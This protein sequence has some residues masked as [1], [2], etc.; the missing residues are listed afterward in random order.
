MQ[1]FSG[2]SLATAAGVAGEVRGAISSWPGLECLQSQSFLVLTNRSW[3]TCRGPVGCRPFKIFGWSP[4]T[5]NFTLCLFDASLS[6][7]E[8][9]AEFHAQGNCL[10]LYQ[11]HP[12]AQLCYAY[13]PCFLE[14]N[15]TYPS[16]YKLQ[17]FIS[18][19]GKTWD[20]VAEGE[21]R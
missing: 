20:E 7:L 11:H 15:S 8:N 17:V 2:H 9:Y 6:D 18:V 16:Q 5:Q 1:S 12:D 19:D 13:R 4:H 10:L 14:A 3:E 21:Y